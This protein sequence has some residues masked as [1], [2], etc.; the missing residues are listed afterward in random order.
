MSEENRWGPCAIVIP[1]KSASDCGERRTGMME[2]MEFWILG[3]SKAPKGRDLQTLL[4]DIS[5]TLSL[6]IDSRGWCATGPCSFPF[7]PVNAL[8][9]MSLSIVLNLLW[10]RPP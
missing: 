9:A 2:T 5:A 8:T 10:I 3:L 6:S 7:V 1:L 4:R